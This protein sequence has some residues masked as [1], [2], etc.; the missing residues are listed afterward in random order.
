MYNRL[1]TVLT[2]SEKGVYKGW[3]STVWD[4]GIVGLRL[5]HFMVLLVG[6]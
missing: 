6:V 2:G 5:C 4:V 3:V 1:I